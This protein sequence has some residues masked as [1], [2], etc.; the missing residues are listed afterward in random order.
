MTLSSPAKLCDPARCVIRCSSKIFEKRKDDEH[1]TCLMNEVIR[2]ASGDIRKAK[3]L[4]TVIGKRVWITFDYDNPKHLDSFKVVG[5]QIKERYI[6]AIHIPSI[7]VHPRVNRWRREN[8]RWQVSFP[9][10][11]KVCSKA[12]DTSFSY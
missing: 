4:G 6:R 9:H 10:L 11:E 3:L 12:V 8:E 1:G 7:E 5:F 2:Y